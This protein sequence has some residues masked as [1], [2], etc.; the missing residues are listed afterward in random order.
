M[1]SFGNNASGVAIQYKLA[2]LEYQT[3]IK[4]AF[5]RKALLRRIEL[6]SHILSIKSNTEL[7][8][9]ECVNIVFNRNLVRQ[10]EAMIDNAL[11]LNNIVSKETVIE[12]LDGIID[13]NKEKERIAG[14]YKRKD[15][16]MAQSHGFNNPQE[17]NN[18][19]DKPF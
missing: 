8:V 7:D 18:S 1:E 9:I 2:G 11:K 19:E 10:T 15:E 13:A 14:E 4:E 16:F 3:S 5:F 12:S 6:I 17:Q